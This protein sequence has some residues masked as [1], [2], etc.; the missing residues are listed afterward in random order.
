MTA[1][2]LIRTVLQEQYPGAWIDGVRF[3]YQDRPLEE[4]DF[5]HLGL[6]EL[7]RR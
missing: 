6:S 5:D 1:G 4:A 3:Y 7:Y 2:T